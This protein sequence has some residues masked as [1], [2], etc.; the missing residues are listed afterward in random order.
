MARKFWV[1]ARPFNKKIVTTALES[2]AEAVMVPK[3]K[4]TAVR[5]LGLIKTVAPDGDLKPGEDVVEV[6]IS[7]EKDEAKAMR[8]PPDKLVLIKT[9]DW[10]VIPLENLIA[11]RG[12]GLLAWVNNAQEAS[13]ALKIMERGV[14]GVVLS[15]T[16][17][18][19]IKK[20]AAVVRERGESLNLIRATIKSVR[21]LGMGDRVCV[22]TITNMRPGQG[23]LVGNSSSGMFLVHAENVE[24]PYCA[25]RPFRVNAGAVH[26]YAR[27]PEG[28]TAYLADISIGD[29]VLIVDQRGRTEVGFVGRAKVE[30]RPMMLVE[31]AYQ[32]KSLSLVMQN[33]ETIRLTR[34]GGEPVSIT[35]L[36]PGDRVL[37]YLEEAGRHFG[38]KIAETIVEK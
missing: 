38:V 36:K 9:S 8:V 24:T 4:S 34:P 27:V 20:T 35:H 22:D 5:E 6:S 17:L 21:P 32:G 29:P 13:I 23:M 12:K 30:K 14:D 26:A 11:K 15:T 16:D 1:N 31:A 19:E 25:T 37:A 18:S 10:K 28:K 33:A 7:S 2:G 3:G